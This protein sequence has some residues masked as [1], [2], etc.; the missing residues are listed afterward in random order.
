VV[1]VN[2]ELG[3]LGPALVSVLA[4]VAE[5]T[6]PLA[7]VKVSVWVPVDVHVLS[8]GGVR[9]E[10]V[11]IRQHFFRYPSSLTPSGVF[12]STLSATRTRAASTLLVIDD[13]STPK[14]SANSRLLSPLSLPDFVNLPSLS[15]QTILPV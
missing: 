10:F 12:R 5:H 1:S 11:D 15:T 14:A 3:P 4:L 7:N 6:P 8:D 9:P 2:F 13:A